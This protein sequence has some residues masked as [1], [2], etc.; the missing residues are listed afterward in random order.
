M[1]NTEEQLGD[2][3]EEVKDHMDDQEGA[4]RGGIITKPYS[5]ADKDNPCVTLMSADLHQVQM[6]VWHNLSILKKAEMHSKMHLTAAT[7]W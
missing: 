2:F 5:P 1:E 6:I 4:K 7:L 3:T